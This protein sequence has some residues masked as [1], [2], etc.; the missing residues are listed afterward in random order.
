MPERRSLGQISLRRAGEIIIY[1][2]FLEPPGAGLHAG[3]V[4]GVA[5]AILP[6]PPDSDVVSGWTK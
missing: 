3:G 4:G 2:V 1:L 6:T 5:G